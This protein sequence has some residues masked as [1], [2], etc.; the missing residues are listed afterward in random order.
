MIQATNHAGW[1]IEQ[2]TRAGWEYFRGPYL[3]RDEADGRMRSYS[4][5]AELTELRVYEALRGAK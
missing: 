2:L 5:W 1:N 3:T 4:E